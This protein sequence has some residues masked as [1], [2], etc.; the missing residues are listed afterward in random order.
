MATV[1]ERILIMQRAMT[2]IMTMMTMATTTTIM[3]MMNMMMTTTTTTMV[4]MMMTTDAAMEDYFG[5]RLQTSDH[6][7]S[8]QLLSWNYN[9]PDVT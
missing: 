9:Y 8:S 6:A 5:A 3:M 1:S 4:M 2:M 7:C